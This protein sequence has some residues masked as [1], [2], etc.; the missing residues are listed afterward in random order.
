M[1]IGDD[2]KKGGIGDSKLVTTRIRGKAQDAS[3][4]EGT[5][6]GA[7]APYRFYRLQTAMIVRVPIM[8]TAFALQ[9]QI[10]IKLNAMPV[11]NRSTLFQFSRVDR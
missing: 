4:Y 9:T 8:A 6:R 1:S 11:P 5:R 7:Q 2:G 10:L 3:R